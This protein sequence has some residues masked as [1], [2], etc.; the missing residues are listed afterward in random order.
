MVAVNID[1]KEFELHFGWGF[2][3]YV[4]REFGV[5]QGEVKTQFGGLYNIYT[6]SSMQDPF[7]LVHIIKAGTVTE[8]QKP[9]NKGIMDFIEGLAEEEKAYEEFY[10]EIW[11]EIAKKPL[12]RK[13]LGDGLSEE[14]VQTM[15]NL[16][17]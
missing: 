15:E 13:A 4:N 9:S 6:G 1:G 14:Y 16:I 10:I 11:D 2:L 3:E 7:T 17:Q 8:K 12:L 5:S